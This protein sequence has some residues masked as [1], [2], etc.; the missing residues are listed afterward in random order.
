MRSRK[1][2][3][4]PSVEAVAWWRVDW[5]EYLSDHDCHFETNRNEIARGRKGCPMSLSRRCWLAIAL[6]AVPN[7]STAAEPAQPPESGKYW[8]FIG[9]YTGTGNDSSRGIYR[10]ELDVRSGRLSKPQLAAEVKNPSFLA[11]RPDGKALYAVEEVGERG[12]K[13]NEGAIHAFKLND[14][15]G[16]L[17]KLNELT[18]GGADPCYVSIN[19]TGRFAIVANYSGGSS[20][21][22]AQRRWQPGFRDRLPPARGEGIERETAGSAARPLR[23][24]QRK[25]IGRRVRLRC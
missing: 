17:T 22:P 18:S 21:L 16:E 11:I 12:E 8:V 23:R 20:A 24:L 2:G 1:W 13:K 25:R 4:G 15:T 5:S 9:T 14:D 10:C 6:L 19:A 3:L 7:R